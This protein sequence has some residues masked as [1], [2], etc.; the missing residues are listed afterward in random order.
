MGCASNLCVHVIDGKRDGGGG[1]V[2]EGVSVLE[3][4]VGEG[5]GFLVAEA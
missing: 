2:A 5:V 4:E 1:G 3:L